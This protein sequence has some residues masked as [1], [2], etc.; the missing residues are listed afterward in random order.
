MKTKMETKKEKREEPEYFLI[1]TNSGGYLIDLYRQNSD[2]VTEE[3]K[4]DEEHTLVLAT[5][6]Y[7]RPTSSSRTIGYVKKQD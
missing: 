1:G 3:K 6:L 2:K 4:S 7:Q 5:K